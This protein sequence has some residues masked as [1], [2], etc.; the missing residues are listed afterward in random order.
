MKL[1]LGARGSALSLAQAGLVAR[2]LNFWAQVEIVKVKTTGDRLS[3]EGVAISWK[4]DFTKELDEALLEG[5]VDFAVHSLKDVPAALPEGLALAAVPLREDPSD[6]LVAHPQRPFSELPQG[7]RVGTS[8]PR[9]KAQLLA[10]RPDLRVVEVRGNVETRIRRLREGRFDAIVLAR[11]GLARLGMLEEIGE[12]FSPDVLL[13]A[14]GQGALALVSR[15]EEGEV[16]ALLARLDD[17][18]SHASVLAERS[19][20]AVLEAGCRAPVAGRARVQGGELQLTAGVFSEDGS[21]VLREEGSGR[22][23]EGIAVGRAVAERLLA[24]G[25]AEWIGGG[26]Q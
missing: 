21:H 2:S 12:V 9:R 6:V 8:S 7:A 24:R 18:D 11:A 5:R 20:L 16:R 4:G 15:A 10:A 1:R 23:A 13:P 14:V 25:A 22:A 3:A 17:A 26:R 19:L